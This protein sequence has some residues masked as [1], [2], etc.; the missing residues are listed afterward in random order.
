[1]FIH[2]RKYDSNNNTYLYIIRRTREKRVYEIAGRRNK[3]W[4][5][6]KMALTKLKLDYQHS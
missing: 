5:F 6:C 4:I 3:L 1:M 2:L